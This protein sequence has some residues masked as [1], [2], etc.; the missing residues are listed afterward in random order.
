MTLRSPF[1]V[2]VGPTGVGKTSFALQ[3][4]QTLRGEIVSADSRQVYRGMDIGT[5][6]PTPSE[7]A[8]VPHHLIDI[9]APDEEFSLADFQDRAYAAIEDIAQ[10]KRL[11]FMVGGTGQY[12]RA[13]VE[14]WRIPRVP[15]DPEL[16]TQLRDQAKRHG[17]QS[18]YERLLEL[19]PAAAT[20]V[21]ARN[22]RRVI[23]ALEVCIRSGHPFSEQRGK[24]PPPYSTLQIGLTMERSALYR[25]AD[26][27]VD[28]MIASG[29]VEEVRSLLEKGYDWTLPAMSGLGYWQFKDY[30]KGSMSLDGA[31]ALIKK[32][33][34][35]F[36]RLQHNW[37][38]TT[39][40]RIRWFDATRSP[41]SSA[42]ELIRETLDLEFR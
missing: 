9:K 17:S 32:E 6:K 31:I 38:R 30:L 21:D 7:L 20:F 15:A 36:I 10:R 22:V 26:V 8:L 35:R 23:R 28:E 24:E 5:A 16:R 42:L 29:L 14:G 41:Y 12:I 34:R 19:D 3:L 25:R 40:P 18:L 37:F 39:D 2:I 1:V 33:T 4:A 27:R 13:V 11:P